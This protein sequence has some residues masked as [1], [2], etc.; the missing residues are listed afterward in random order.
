MSLLP[1]LCTPFLGSSRYNGA[2]KH[3]EWLRGQL[4]GEINETV[5]RA[6]HSAALSGTHNLQLFLEAFVEAYF[7]E[8][9]ANEENLHMD[10]VLLEILQ[11]HWQQLIVE[12]VVPY[13][14]LKSLQARTSFTRA[15]APSAQFLLQKNE[16]RVRFF[17]YWS[18][19]LS[20]TTPL[21]VSPLTSLSII[22]RGP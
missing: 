18:L 17:A 3:V 19:Q 2:E 12:G 20:G 4:K 21:W 16:T 7:E 6:I 5:D 8:K 22:P 13:L 15:R 10:K 9:G 11:R 14:S 1:M